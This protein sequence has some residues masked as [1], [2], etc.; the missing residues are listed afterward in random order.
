MER[1]KIPAIPLEKALE[2]YRQAIE[3]GIEDTRRWAFCC[4]ATKGR[5]SLRPLGIGEDLL[6]LDFMARPHAWLSISELATEVLSSAFPELTIKKL[7]NFGFI[8]YR[9]GASTT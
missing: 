7:E 4:R 3:A 2:N 6:E 9:P 8:Q 5:K 1:G